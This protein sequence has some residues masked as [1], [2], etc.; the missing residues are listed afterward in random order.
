M[1]ATP[2]L[3]EIQLFSFA[4]PPKGWALCNGQILPIAQNQAL[5]SLLG[6]TY[7]G[8]GTTNFALPD[9]RCRAAIHV[10][11]GHILGEAGGADFVTPTTAQMPAHQHV[12]DLKGVTLTPRA[13]NA[14]GNQRTPVAGT[15]AIAG[16]PD[17]AY[18]SAVPDQNMASG[19]VAFDGTIAAANAG[20]SQPHENRQPFLAMNYCIALQGIFPSPN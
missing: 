9:L 20:G 5:F 7:G 2:Y 1:S 12:I 6:T 19:G 13:R 10:G 16:T 17:F 3:S 11:A 18:S 15:P 8:N 14:A 4:F